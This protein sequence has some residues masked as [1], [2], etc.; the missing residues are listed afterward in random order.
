MIKL[1]KS[2][3]ILFNRNIFFIKEDNI[4]IKI[5]NYKYFKLLINK[6]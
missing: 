3:N 1:I 6:I 5:Y 2:D 4:K